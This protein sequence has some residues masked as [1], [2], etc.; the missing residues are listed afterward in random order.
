MNLVWPHA[1]RYRDYVVDAINRDLPYDEFL[2]QQ[3]AGDLLPAASD[4]LRASQTI[5]TGLLALGA[6][7]YE[8]GGSREKYLLE[9][10][11]DQIDVVARGMLG[12]DRKSVV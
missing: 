6:K 10:A 7:S 3:I 1:W 5:A 12:L 11:D 4:E 8:E 2:R 9:Q